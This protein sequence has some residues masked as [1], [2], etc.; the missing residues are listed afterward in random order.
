MMKLR[1]GLIGVL[2]MV[3]NACGGIP[4]TV[5]I[6]TGRG[7]MLDDRGARESRINAA[8]RAQ[9]DARM[10]LLRFAESLPA[11][12]GNLVGDYMAL[13][14]VTAVRVRSLIYSA[15]QYAARYF[16]DGTVEV[17]VGIDPEDI[18]RVVRETQP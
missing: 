15:R 9:Q 8:A 16:D 1:A 17:D 10:K 2:I 7:R 13:N 5:H 12:N 4:P 14:P 11:G 3:L 6:E 18:L